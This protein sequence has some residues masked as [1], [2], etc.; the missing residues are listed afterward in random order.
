VRANVNGRIEGSPDCGFEAELAPDLPLPVQLFIA[1]LV[2][3]LARRRDLAA[4][5]WGGDAAG[6]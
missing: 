1:W 6:R 5:S 4:T 2:L 3:L